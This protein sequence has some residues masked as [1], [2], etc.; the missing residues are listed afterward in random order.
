MSSMS[1]TFNARGG[2][3]GE[4]TAAPAPYLFNMTAQISTVKLDGGLSI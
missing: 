4:A 1:H 2:A 3:L